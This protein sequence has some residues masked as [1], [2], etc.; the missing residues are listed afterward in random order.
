MVRKCI[1]M[2]IDDEFFTEERCHILELLNDSEDPTQSLARARVEPGVTTAWH[3]LKGTS[4][5]YFILSGE[6][7]VELGEDF[8][9]E[10]SANDVVRI[11]AD[12][13]QRI[14]NFGTEDLIFLCFCQPAFSDDCYEELE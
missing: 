1:S 8:V 9:K 12:H 11:P 3:R 10:V 4:E 14:S 2:N 6:G 13:A 5:I 7:Q